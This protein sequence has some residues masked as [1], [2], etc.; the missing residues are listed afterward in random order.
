VVGATDADADPG[1]AAAVDGNDGGAGDGAPTVPAGG[2]AK[3]GS[4]SAEG[5]VVQ[6]GPLC[7]RGPPRGRRGKWYP[8]WGGDAGGGGGRRGGDPG[9]GARGRPR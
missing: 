1:A 2:V 8:T 7:A 3:D 4:I 9:T 6:R 5:D